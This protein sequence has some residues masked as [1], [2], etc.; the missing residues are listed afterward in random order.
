MHIALPITFF[1]AAFFLVV[2]AVYAAP[3]EC[4]IG[5][6]IVLTGIPV[7]LI[8]VKYQQK[9]PKWFDKGMGEFHQK[10]LCN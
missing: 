1:L 2:M 9:Q 6:A 7:Y 5:M 10:A 3:K 8:G 4:I